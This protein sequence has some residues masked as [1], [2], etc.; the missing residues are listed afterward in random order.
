LK[1]FL[2]KIRVTKKSSRA[3]AEKLQNRKQILEKFANRL[4]LRSGVNVI[5][6]KIAWP[7]KIGEN[8]AVFYSKHCEFNHN[9][10]LLENRR[11]LV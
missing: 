3:G 8:I 5:I 1:I 11:K 7:K 4:K 2:S 9:N 6:L 10:D